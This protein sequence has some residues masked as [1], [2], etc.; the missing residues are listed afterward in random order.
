MQ[1]VIDGF[2]G[3]DAAP[4]TPPVRLIPALLL[5]VHVLAQA[6][7]FFGRKLLLRVD[8]RLADD[9]LRTALRV[10]L[11]LLLAA[12]DTCRRGVTLDVL[13]IATASSGLVDSAA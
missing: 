4:G 7:L 8:L 12:V 10:V 2:G 11:L 9:V 1:R 13:L 6:R 5:L 3:A